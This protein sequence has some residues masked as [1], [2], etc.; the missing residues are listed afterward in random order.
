MET[1]N[2]MGD[3]EIFPKSK[4]S[5]DFPVFSLAINK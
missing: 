3:K 2:G 4:M 5:E 1:G